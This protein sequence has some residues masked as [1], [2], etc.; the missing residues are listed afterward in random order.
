MKLVIYKYVGLQKYKNRF[1]KV[2]EFQFTRHG[3][4]FEKCKMLKYNDMCLWLY[5][6]ESSIYENESFYF[7]YS[8]LYENAR[9]VI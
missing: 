1:F 2:G 5:E 8:F 3:L 7:L 9:R 6:N 4:F